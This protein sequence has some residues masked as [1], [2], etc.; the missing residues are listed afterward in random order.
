MASS[1]N[2]ISI[3]NCLSQSYKLYN[4]YNKWTF[5]TTVLNIY[6]TVSAK[7][8][9]LNLKTV[10]INWWI[11]LLQLENASHNQIILFLLLTLKIWTFEKC[12]TLLPK[13]NSYCCRKSNVRGPR[14]KI[15]SEGLST[16]IDI[17]VQSTIQVPTEADVG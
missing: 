16:E 1:H 6:S 12:T 11:S 3:I 17:L 5:I 4:S 13:G 7:P 14:F 2:N 8:R 15:A 9:E 10:I